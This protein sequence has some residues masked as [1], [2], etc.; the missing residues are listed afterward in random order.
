MSQTKKRRVNYKKFRV[1][2]ECNK[3]GYKWVSNKSKHGDFPSQSTRCP[4]PTCRVYMYTLSSPKTPGFHI[5]FR[6]SKY[7]V[8]FGS[9]PLNTP[10]RV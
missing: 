1:P 4:N 8:Y 9:K 3:C 5:E 10:S 2:R 6:L 7:K